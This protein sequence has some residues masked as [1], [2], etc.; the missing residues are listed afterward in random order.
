MSKE[1]YDLVQLAKQAMREKG[2]QPDFPHEVFQ[3][4]DQIKSFAPDPEAYTDLRKLLWC[5]IDNDDSLDLDQLTYAQKEAS[6]KTALWVAIADV[7]SIVFKGTPIDLHAQKNTTSVY[8]PA[9]MFPMLPEILSTNL[10]S[11]NENEDRLAIV[12][13]MTMNSSGNI[14]DS[15][16]FQAIVHNYAKLAYDAVGSWLEGKKAIPEKIKLKEGLEHALRCQHETAQ[17]LR[18]NRHRAGSLT[19]ESPGAIAKLR[20]NNE[21]VLEIPQHNF[22]HQLIEEFMIASNSAIAYHFR[23]AKIPSLRRVVRV[24]KRWSQIVEVAARLGERLPNQ[25]DSKALDAFLIKMKKADPEAF[26]IFL[27]S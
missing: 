22:A 10:T 8:T 26:P 15:S 1:S 4:L 7:D 25:P 5:S 2:L 18:Q 3:Q 12:V 23:H 11:L 21:V 16:I 17:I 24:P 27:W 19:L 6:G 20:E 9:K 13:K 14:E